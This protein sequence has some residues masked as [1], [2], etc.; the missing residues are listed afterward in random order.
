[1]KLFIEVFLQ[2]VLSFFAIMFITRI[3][4]RQQVAQLTLYEYINGITFGSIAANL[5]T[6]VGQR[7]WQHLTGLIL[8]G[9]LTLIVAFF[10]M[11]NR[12][13]SKI[14]QGEPVMVIQEGKILEGNLKRYHYTI[15]DLNVLLRRKDIFDIGDVKYAILESTGEISVMKRD[16]IRPVTLEDLKLSPDAT[17]EMQLEVMVTGSIIYEN[18]KSRGLT[19]QW[20]LSR[21]REQNI[22]S[23][24]DVFY[25]VLD[26]DNALLVDLYDDYLQ[27]RK[28]ISESDEN[29]QDQ[30]RPNR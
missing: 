17:K 18:L 20:L 26:A 22:V 19:A 14:I 9:I 10:V 16:E 15:D 11:K 28:G 24:K 1:M 29:P 2:T 27:Q 21:L 6:D 7:S 12:T 30:N 23:V 25:G 3:L 13:A 8:Y 5:A 4:G